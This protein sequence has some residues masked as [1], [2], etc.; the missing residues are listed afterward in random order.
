M[1]EAQRCPVLFSYI[2]GIV[3]RDRRPGLFV[4]TGS[5][6]FGLI[7]RVTQSLAGRVGLLHLLSFSIKELNK[8]CN[9]ITPCDLWRQRKP[10]T[11]KD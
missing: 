5:R 6:Q 3:D 11:F 10:T 1:D 9:E 8:S 2:Q 4:L 7:A